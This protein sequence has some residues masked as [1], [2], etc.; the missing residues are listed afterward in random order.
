MA[1][2]LSPIKRKLSYDVAH[3]IARDMIDNGWEDGHLIG[4]EPKLPQRYAISRDMFREALRGPERQGLIRT[5]RGLGGGLM[6][7]KPPNE[8]ILNILRTY[9]VETEWTQDVP[10]GGERCVLRSG[11]RLTRSHCGAHLR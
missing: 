3:R 7:A 2:A 6:A 5:R 9:L 10:V 4:R 1:N 8:A 11:R